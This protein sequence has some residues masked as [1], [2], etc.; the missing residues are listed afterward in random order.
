MTHPTRTDEELIAECR[1]GNDAA[2]FALAGRY[3][4]ALANSA[5]RLTGAPA[6][7]V[8][9]D[10]ILRVRT[11]RRQFDQKHPFYL[12][13]Y[14]RVLRRSRST[15]PP[16]R[17]KTEPATPAEALALVSELTAAGAQV[18]APSVDEQ[19]QWALTRVPRKLR[20]CLVLHEIHGMGPEELGRVVRRSPRAVERLI[21]AS[22]TR[23]LQEVR[24][25]TALVASAA[26]QTPES[27]ADDMRRLRSLLR[28]LE[29]KSAP[30]F[31]EANLLQAILLWEDTRRSRLRRALYLAS[32]L[33]AVVLA[34][35]LVLDPGLRCA[36]REGGVLPSF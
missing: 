36:A 34:I 8:V 14:R 25:G 31:F 20:V 9:R 7:E 6:D 5:Y 19:M 2:L 21:T 4:D 17:L 29:W 13:A 18:Q 27:S 28:E 22:A 30:W 23:L 16:P 32:I 33:I 10:V 12:W 24:A 1:S 15:S 35:A 26:R 3:K 11:S